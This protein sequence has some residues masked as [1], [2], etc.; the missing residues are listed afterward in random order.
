MSYEH[1][2]NRRQVLG[3]GELLAGPLP[4]LSCPAAFGT[5]SYGE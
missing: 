5:V 3:Q 4:T 1:A 2:G